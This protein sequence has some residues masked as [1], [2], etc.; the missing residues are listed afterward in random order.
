MKRATPSILLAF[1]HAG[2]QA[3]VWLSNPGVGVYFKGE[4]F[5]IWWQ[6]LSVWTPIPWGDMRVSLAHIG[7]LVRRA[8]QLYSGTQKQD[9]A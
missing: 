9:Q 5:G 8:E 7:S 3:L 2:M 1:V 6:S 4:S